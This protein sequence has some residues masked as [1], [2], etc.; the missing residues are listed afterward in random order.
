MANTL[1]LDEGRE[2][3]LRLA[4]SINATN[5][6]TALMRS[7]GTVGLDTDMVQQLTAPFL[8]TAKPATGAAALAPIKGVGQDKSFAEMLKGVPGTG[9][10]AKTLDGIKNSIPS[11]KN[12][13]QW[14]S[15]VSGGIIPNGPKITLTNGTTAQDILNQFG[16]YNNQGIG[17]LPNL[18]QASAAFN[19]PTDLENIF[20]LLGIDA[21]AIKKPAESTTPEPKKTDEPAK[22]TAVATTNVFSE[23][24]DQKGLTDYIENNNGNDLTFDD[25]GQPMV[26]G[27]KLKKGVTYWFNVDKNDANKKVSIKWDGKAV[28]KIENGQS[29]GTL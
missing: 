8:G 1:P 15:T 26:N 10:I 20:K 23:I 25:K 17:T 13:Y 2:E 29:V 21:A 5:Y 19:Q 7:V 18:T 22:T 3:R 27:Q 24:K 16:V 6:A 11:Y 14:G 12:G 9:D 4:M 28:H